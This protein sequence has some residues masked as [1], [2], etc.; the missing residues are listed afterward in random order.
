MKRTFPLLP[1]LTCIIML[2]TLRLSAQQGNPENIIFLIGDGMGTGQV[3][4]MKTL[5]GDIALDDFPVAGF[6]L[7]QSLNGFVTESAA[8]GTALSTGERTNNYLIA[9]RPDGTDLLTLLE[10]ARAKGKSVGVIATSSVT[11]ATPASFLSHAAHRNQEFDIAVQIAA[12]G[13]DVIIGGGR[14][15]FLPEGNGG[16]RE[17]GRNLI[18]EMKAEGYT[19]AETAS[20]DIPSAGRLV[21]LL[22]DEGLPSASRREFSLRMLTETA[23]RLLSTSAEGFVLLIE[24]SQID[25]AAHDNDFEELKEEL[26]DFDGAIDAALDFAKVSSKTLIVVTADH[27]TG[28]LAVLGKDPD[29]TDMRGAW[30]SGDHT[31]NMVPV[32]AY[33]TRAEI[34]G[35]IHLNSEVGRLLQGLLP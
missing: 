30:I 35:G 1:A 32:F 22:A 21:W 5:L 13:A 33:G 27:E 8:G 17:D 7:T 2:T 24:G 23:I 20:D 4:A 19:Y 34:F 29:G 3:T 25:W 15:F 11:H 6:S 9:K 12:S 10:A 26:G 16:D 18:A 14:R 31:G 28:G